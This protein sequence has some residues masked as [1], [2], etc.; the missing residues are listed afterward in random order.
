MDV[1]WNKGVLAGTW[2]SASLIL[3]ADP[4]VAANAPQMG[5]VPAWVR[6]PPATPVEKDDLK[7][8][9]V[10]ILY[11]DAQLSFDADG[12]TE[13]HEVVARVQTP[14]GLQAL[15]TIAYQW[16]PWSDTLTFH[17]AVI[18]RDGQ[19]IDIL[20]KDG[21]FT[22]LRRE[23]GL[24]QAMLTG[25]L[26][27]LLQP[28]GLQVGD[29]L[30][31]AVS[32]RHADPL[33]KGQIAAL[34]AN[35]DTTPVGHMRLQAHWPSSLPVKWRE[36]PGLPPLRRTDAGGV[37]T[38][39]LDLDD[40]HPPILPA[41]APRRFLH[42]RQVEFTT[43][44]D[45]KAVAQ[46]MAPLFAKAAELGPQ[47]PV[48]AQAA[49]IAKATE[50]PKQRAA[51]ALR[52]VQGQVRYLAHAQD[53]GGLMPQSADE[54]WRL[55]YGD[56]KAK[57][58]LLMAL[59]REL[60]VPAEPVLATT[61]AGDGLNAY[62]PAP[63]LFNHVLVRVRLGGHDY[64]LD[65][66]REGDRDLDGLATP[67]FGWVLPLDTPDGQL[68]H[69]DPSPASRPLVSQVIRYDASGGVTAPAHT[70]LE[71]TVRDDAA[72]F[73]HA[74]LSAVPPERVESA[75]KA[76]WTAAHTKFT[77]VHVAQAWDP[78]AR[79]LK[80]TADGTSTLDWSGAGLDL[81]EV[82]F[83]G[84]P[85]IKRDPA[86][87]D[88]DA[89]YVTEFPA[90]V[91]TDESV[92]LPPGDTVAP[93][94]AKASDVDTVIGGVAYRRK[95]TV[96]GNVFRVD[97]S[98]RALKPEISASE[99]RAAV[100]PLTKFGNQGVFA[101]AGSQ[102]QAANDAAALDSQPT[103]AD[104]HA[105][106][107]NALLDAGRFRDALQEYDAAI[108]LDPKSQRGWAGR[109]VVHA[110]LGDRSAIADADKADALGPPE[111]AAARARAI[112]AAG[113]GDVEGA[114]AAYRRAL[115]IAPDDD[116]SLRR[117][118]N[119]DIDSSDFD[120]AR[121]DLDHLLRAHP[122]LASNSHLWRATIE[123]AARQKGAAEKELGQMEVATPDAR[124][125]RANLY[126]RL[127]D[128]DLA[129][130]DVDEAIRLRPTAAA[131][132]KRAEI[133]G[134]Y[135]STAANADV[136]AALKLTPDDM[137][138]QVWRADAAMARHDFAAALAQTDRLVSQ[139]PEVAGRLLLARA[140]IEGKLG[141]AAAMDTDFTKARAMA[142]DAAPDPAYLC[143]SELSAKWRPQTAL[144][145]CEKAIQSVPNDVDLHL[146]R[147]VLLHRLGRAADAEAA[148]ASL[149]ATTH[150]PIQL[151][152]ICYTL[153]VENMELDSDLALCDASL[154]LEPQEAA[155]LDS[156]AF[157]LMRLG[158]NAEALTAYDAALAA[159]PDLYES[160]YGRGLVEAR[161]GRSTQSERD[162]ADA[163]KGR[164]Q[165]REEFAE[166]GLR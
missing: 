5:P 32:I 16:S 49:L 112:L 70:Q 165:I 160:L 51:A 30:D 98:I 72:V 155:T 161:L 102:A 100:D 38:V 42:G 35:W 131:W 157:V 141:Q 143:R 19:T 117:L 130:A 95:G 84:A 134:G 144:A 129:R 10:V 118:I 34:V 56:C 31:V 127:D 48:V 47:S 4:G 90:W 79:E 92:V 85:D 66:T 119:L 18:S 128:K 78:D 76:Y 136:D 23:T 120:G 122:E 1:G 62:L 89:P 146:S 41:H 33:L 75:L 12:W 17:R 58:V 11:H 105:D 65:G 121:K 29:V 145:D 39:E 106:R 71:T 81:H 126:F 132:L 77:P 52:L 158:R 116:Y 137:D 114:R 154:K 99:A 110:W 104:G 25:E 162:I 67:A 164:P 68:I 163:L 36:T 8:L 60:G 28:E 87:S 44:A 9:P 69:L 96:T 15:N 166:M 26:T 45:W 27:A 53:G 80:L 149:K 46:V 148:F 61:I 2:A 133:D 107:G 108:A 43:L 7:G 153:A 82:E 86:A 14:E 159:K 123:A 37:T 50:D 111:I 57:T 22:V 20:P 63:Q 59:L 140:Q 109:A 6:P 24:E 21:A 152:D 147:L 74:K 138:A 115:K 135:A 151:N 101:P 156:R 142:G 55:R 40:V 3:L 93:D 113:E 91:E 54:T 64:W 103:T 150:N 125:D 139:H 97:L 13:Y 83:G 124:L 94:A 73:L 88:P